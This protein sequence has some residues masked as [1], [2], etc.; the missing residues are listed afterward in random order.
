MRFARVPISRNLESFDHFRDVGALIKFR[1]PKV[2]WTIVTPA[3]DK[4]RQHFSRIAKSR[5]ALVPI[6]Q[7]QQRAD[8]RWIS[9]FQGDTF[10]PEK[11]RISPG[12]D[13]GYCGW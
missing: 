9:E 6:F 5:Q 1:P 2:T 3:S 4:S 12:K 13:V 10:S 7:P 8:R 11:I